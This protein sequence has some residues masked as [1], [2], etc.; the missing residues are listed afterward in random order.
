[1]PHWGSERGAAPPFYF[2]F[3]CR[4]RASS[5][6]AVRFEASSAAGEGREEP[7]G[8]CHVR[9][10]RLAAHGAV[11][12]AHQDDFGPVDLPTATLSRRDRLVRQQPAGRRGGINRRHYHRLSGLMILLCLRTSK[13]RTPKAGYNSKSKS[14]KTIAFFQTTSVS[15][16]R[17]SKWCSM[18]SYPH[19]RTRV[20]YVT[21]ANTHFALRL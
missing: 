2:I 10:R 20:R 3:G 8:M 21:R 1:M 11:G 15:F 9:T 7:F 19:T 12:H 17:K 4:L 14:P 18:Y 16:F 5:A 13:H 6:V